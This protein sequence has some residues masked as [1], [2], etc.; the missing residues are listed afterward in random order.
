MA[1]P[2]S[3]KKNQIAAKGQELYDRKLRNKLEP[4]YR[5]QIVAIEIDSEDYFLGASFVE[6]VKKAKKKYPDKLFYFVKVGF[7]AV[8]IHR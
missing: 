5:G 1:S 2:K 8:N 6:A 3:A 4:E 7:P